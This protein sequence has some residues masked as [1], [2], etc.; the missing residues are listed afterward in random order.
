[1]TQPQEAQG[2][3][4]T[5]TAP[6]KGPEDTKFSNALFVPVGVTQPEPKK[7]AAETPAQ[8]Q[9][10]QQQPEA[11]ASADLSN[12]VQGMKFPDCPR[13]E[14]TI[15]PELKQK[16]G[17]DFDYT[18]Q[19]AE[20]LEK[21]QKITRRKKMQGN[22]MLEVLEILLADKSKLTYLPDFKGQGEFI[23]NPG[24]LFGK[25][26]EETAKATIAMAISKGWE[27]VKL[28]G[29]NEYKDMLWLE[30][31]RQGIEVNGYRPDLRSP[32]WAKLKEEDPEKHKSAMQGE[33]SSRFTPLKADTERKPATKVEAPQ[34]L[35]LVEEN[36]KRESPESTST[37]SGQT[38]PAQTAKDTAPPIQSNIGANTLARQTPPA[39]GEKFE[40]WIERMIHGAQ[41]NEEKRGL[42]QL[43]EALASGKLKMDEAQ[44]AVFKGKL[45]SPVVN[46]KGQPLGGYNAAIADVENIAKAQKADIT[47]PRAPDKDASSAAPSIIVASGYKSRGVGGP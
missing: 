19:L 41:S 3:T 31:Q 21:A 1:M 25:F 4:A 12:K 34:E 26:T 37:I 46:D 13:F 11:E 38:F 10:Q 14:N 18:R 17:D 23:G 43:G 32:V 30:A 9:Q 44:K 15:L 42:D 28:H 24:G 36:G 45:Q 16:F 6:E 35:K 27:S 39:T 8:P 47:F 20:A 5:A 33:P 2:T 22:T 40:Q 7:P 29:S